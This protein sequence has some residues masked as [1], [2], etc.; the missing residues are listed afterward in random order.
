M[1]HSTKLRD[2]YFFLLSSCVA[3]LPATFLVLGHET[4]TQE[5]QVNQAANP[6]LPR[7][8]KM[9]SGD[10]DLINLFFFFR[11]RLNFVLSIYGTTTEIF[12][13]FDGEK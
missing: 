6:S 4:R 7:S 3:S 10:I 8:L 9:P 13:T 12:L 2:N 1:R 11:S 5:K